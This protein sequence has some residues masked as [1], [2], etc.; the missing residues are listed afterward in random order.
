VLLG[1]HDLVYV[2]VGKRGRKEQGDK[3]SVFRMLKDSISGDVVTV[4]HPHT[5]EVIGYQI[6]NLGVLELTQVDA[7]VSQAVILES[8]VEIQ[9]GDLIL[10]YLQPLEEKVEVVDTGEDIVKGS[11]IASRNNVRLIGQSHV[12]Y[13]DV[14]SNDKV[15]RGN[16]FYVYKPCEII[17]DG[18]NSD[19][20]RI[21][22]KI[23]GHAVVLEALETTSVA[24][25]IDATQ[26]I[27]IG[28]YVLMSRY[29]RWE[30]EGVSQDYDVSSCRS[31]P[32]CMLITGEERD[33]GVKSPYCEVVVEQ[34]QT[35]APK[36]TLKERLG[37]KDKEEAP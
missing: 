20:V 31:D 30:T 8:F 26:E 2:D 24:L 34:G 19:N 3:F 37:I 4:K 29:N 9:N 6:V 18:T 12:V 17:P 15:M 14:G 35:Q 36:P 5:G 16:L 23:I 21:P 28:E 27:A 11:I 22:E 7:D 32:K 1:E 10:P 33:R 13:L 25:I